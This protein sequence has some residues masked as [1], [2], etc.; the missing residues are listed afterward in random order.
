MLGDAVLR[1]EDYVHSYP[2]DWRTHQPVIT[3]A[4]LQWFVR[5][6]KIKEAAL[7]A[8]EDVKAF[9]DPD[10]TKTEMVQRVLQVCA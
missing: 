9:P 4:S 6:E 1:R 7:A 3:V 5:N 10:K 8:L 2:Y